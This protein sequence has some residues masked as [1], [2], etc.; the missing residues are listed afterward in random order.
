LESLHHDQEIRKPE[1]VLRTAV[2]LKE[3]GDDG[4][5]LLPQTD[6]ARSP[7]E[8]SAFKDGHNLSN[9]QADR[10]FLENAKQ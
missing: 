5:P 7:S 8:I 10:T 4:E 2:F 3:S 9:E 6:P 1:A